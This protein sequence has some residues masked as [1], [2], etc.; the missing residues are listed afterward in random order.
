MDNKIKSMNGK[1]KS[2]DVDGKSAGVTKINV[3]VTD[4]V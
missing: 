4:D 3:Y 1:N 2:Q